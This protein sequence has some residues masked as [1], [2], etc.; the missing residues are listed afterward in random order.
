LFP[1]TL[2]FDATTWNQPQK[3]TLSTAQDANTISEVLSLKLKDPTGAATERD[4][5][6]HAKDDDILDLELSTTQ[7]SVTEGSPSGSILSVSLTQ[8]P[9][10]PIQIDLSA[11]KVHLSRTSLMFDANNCSPPVDVTA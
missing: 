7:L 3:I 9:S 10:S 11:A 6:V 1:D 8:Q 4:L 2:Q 5:L